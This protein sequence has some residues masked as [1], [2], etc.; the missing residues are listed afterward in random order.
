MSPCSRVFHVWRSSVEGA[1]PISPCGG[2]AS[3]RR[4]L[5]RTYGVRDTGE[6]NARNVAR[7]SVHALCKALF[8]AWRKRGEGGRTK[9]PNRLCGFRVEIF[10]KKSSTIVELKDS[11]KRSSEVSESLVREAATNRCSPKASEA[12]VPPRG[13]QPQV[14]LQACKGKVSS[15]GGAKEQDALGSLDSDRSREVVDLAA[16]NVSY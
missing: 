1:V 16:G 14:R 2:L 13:S 10:R 15:R 8:V 5:G 4:K 3:G 12:S 9:V 6:T 11:C 7:G